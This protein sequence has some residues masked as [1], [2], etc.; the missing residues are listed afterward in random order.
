MSQEPL[1][2]GILAVLALVGVASVVL[3]R[4]RIPVQNPVLDSDTDPD[5]LAPRLPGA[6]L[7]GAVRDL[8]NRSMG[9]YMLRQLLGRPVETFERS[10]FPAPLTAH[11]VARRIGHAALTQKANLSRT[12]VARPGPVAAAIAT[13]PGP[14]RPLPDPVP[15]RP[16]QAHRRLIRDTGAALGGLVAIALLSSAVASPKPAG[17]V[18][19]QSAT[20]IPTTAPTTGAET[21]PTPP[22]PP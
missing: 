12:A 9:A 11:Q 2:I 7:L 4:R 5:A 16:V 13:L 15:S 22:P 18:L 14:K 10:T 20:P 21:P 1:A 3:R 8:L 19:G 6:A 17:G